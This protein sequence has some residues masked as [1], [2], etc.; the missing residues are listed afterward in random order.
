MVRI[1]LDVGGTFTDVVALD[2]ATGATA[3]F[4]VPTNVT[5]PSAGVLDAIAATGVAYEDV[6]TVRLGT[7][8]GVNAL[9]TGSGAPT[10][11]ITTAGFRDVLEIRR[12][13]RK[14]LFDLDETFPAPLVPRDLRLEVSERVGAEGAVVTPLDED[15][16]RRAWRQLRAA[17]VE[18]VA[19]VFLF[20]FE[21]PAHEQRAREIVLEEGGAQS[22][23]ISSDV[24]P[25]YREYERTS[26]TVAAARIAGTVE[27]YLHDLG[28]ELKQRGLRDGR[29]SIMT[30]SGGALSSSTV[31]QLPISTLLSGPVGGV[32]A[33]RRLA[34]DVGWRDVLTLDMGGTSCDVSGIVDGIPDERLDMEIDGHTISYPTYD[35]ETIGAGGGSIAWIDSGGSMRV[36]PRSAGSRPGP[37]C[38]GRGGI[39][40]TVTDA[41][42]V[43]GRYD[44]KALLGGSVHLDRELARAAIETHVAT[45]LGISVEQAAAG[46]IRIVNVL[47]TNAV[48]TISVERGRDVRDFT[49]VAYGGAGP[50]HAAEIARELGIPRVLVPP[51]PGCASAFGAVTSGS[52]RDFLRT[53]AR[54]VERVDLG[55][56][57]AL[58]AQLRADAHAA[59]KDE[60]FDDELV[61]VETWLDVRYEGQAHELSVQLDDAALDG[62]ALAAAVGRFH[63]LHRKLYGHAFHDVPV[64]LVNLRVK[65]FA[66]HPDPGMWWDWERIYA[67]A[68]RLAPQRRVW[69]EGDGD[70]VDATIVRRD[71]LAPGELLEGPAVIHQVD[72]TV[73]V[74]PGFTAEALAGGSLVLTDRE[75]GSAA[76]GRAAAVRREPAEVA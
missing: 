71:G 14:H 25:S 22:V 43:L 31:A 40:P 53:I 33:A 51:F 59:L 68:P 38:Y 16:V 3:W 63:T 17:G 60:G 65:G 4:K 50:A 28:D 6:L 35:I 21:N 47:M 18:A 57:G 34:G 48:R 15:G 2:E 41:N 39:E 45:P 26:T 69:V 75:H 10:G 58:N 54:S 74:P 30:N 56:A 72:A 13:H 37:A 55:A 24:L 12:T 52:R 76:P 27:Q 44:T 7:T 70:F 66:R 1:G 62:D 23:F 11:L 5:S 46:I 20:S 19:I 32:E 9:L 29:L 73:L 61:H 36:G 67:D 42:L 64:E 8:L 49:L